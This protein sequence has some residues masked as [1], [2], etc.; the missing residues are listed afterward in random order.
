MF[1]IFKVIMVKKMVLR[2][3]SLLRWSA[4]IKSLENAATSIAF[5]MEK[6]GR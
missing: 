5:Y 1:L 6:N 2:Q 3:E 4:N